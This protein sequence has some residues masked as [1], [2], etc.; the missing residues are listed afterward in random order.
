MSVSAEKTVEPAVR[1]SSHLRFHLWMACILTAM[2]VMDYAGCKLMQIHTHIGGS[3]IAL[4]LVLAMIS[5]LPIYWHEKHRIALRESTLV[6]PW[7]AALAILLPYAVL[8]AARFRM[9]LQDSVYGRFDQTLGVSVPAILAWSHT[10]WLGALITST[11][12][13]IIPIINLAALVP[14]LLGKAKYAREFL[15]SNLIAF[16]IGLPL[17]ALVPAIGPWVY[18]HFAPTR[19][20]ALC[21]IQLLGLRHPGP[22]FTYLSDAGGL[23]CFPSFH[24]IWAILCANAFWGFRPLRIPVAVLS[25]LIIASTLTSGW[26][27]F[28]DVIAGV[29]IAGVSLAIA[30]LC[31]RNLKPGF[32]RAEATS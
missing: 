18:F 14:Q 25:A 3:V 8:I 10:H 5:P 31:T 28:T 12:P 17:F 20:Q 32:D 7:E 23:V 9:P 22:F 4:A 27:Y 19:S 16:A 21:G 2:A 13:L 29:L 24:V 11:Y 30:K 1:S 26:H 15:L 6:L